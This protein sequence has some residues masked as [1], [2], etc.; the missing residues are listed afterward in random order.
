[1]GPLDALIRAALRRQ[2]P[3]AG[4][5][6]RVMARVAAEPAPRLGWIRR[7]KALLGLP[8]R[9]WAAVGAVACLLLLIGVVQ[10]RR[11]QRAEGEMAKVQLKQA[12]HIASSKL[13]LARKRVQEIDR[14]SPES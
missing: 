10:Y 3:P 12:L 4:F 8:R 6:E 5:A 7:V 11:E 9:R 14:R 13:N 2:E 1:M